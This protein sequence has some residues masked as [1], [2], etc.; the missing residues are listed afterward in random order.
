MWLF[1]RDAINTLIWGAFVSWANL[2]LQWQSVTRTLR[3]SVITDCPQTAF[4]EHIP[5]QMTEDRIH[6]INENKSRCDQWKHVQNTYTFGGEEKQLPLQGKGVWQAYQYIILCRAITQAW[7]GCQCWTRSCLHMHACGVHVNLN[8]KTQL[9]PV[10]SSRKNTRCWTNARLR[11]WNNIKPAL[12]QHL[13]GLI[14]R[15]VT[16]SS[17]HIKC[18]RLYDKRTHENEMNRALGHLCAHIG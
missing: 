6:R 1:L 16:M 12:V 13:V 4:K 5:C 7:Q 2:L 3:D 15:P 18:W 17:V 8:K 9:R 14:L 11:R 10:L